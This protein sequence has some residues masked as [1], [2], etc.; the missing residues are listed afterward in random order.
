MMSEYLQYNYWTTKIMKSITFGVLTAVKIHSMTFW[1]MT[2]C[3]L[4]DW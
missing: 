2:P 1:V 4:V 3:S